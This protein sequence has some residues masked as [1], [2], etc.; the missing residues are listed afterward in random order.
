MREG[1]VRE[2]VVPLPTYPHAGGISQ[3]GFPLLGRGLLDILAAD[4]GVET[5]VGLGML[6]WMRVWEGR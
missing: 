5:E 3:L 6:T 1:V 2:G 4:G